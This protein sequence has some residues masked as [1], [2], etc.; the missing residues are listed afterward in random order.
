MYFTWGSVLE[1]RIG[2]ER[3]K[4]PKAT[5]PVLP[6]KVRRNTSKYKGIILPDG[7]K[8]AVRKPLKA[9]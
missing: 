9:P 5:K 1:G 8:K 2:D 7:Q 4:F 3:I 6:R